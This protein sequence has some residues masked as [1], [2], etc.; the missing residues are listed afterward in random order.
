MNHAAGIPVHCI[1]AEDTNNFFTTND[2]VTDLL[3]IMSVHPMREDILKNLLY[4]KKYSE[5]VLQHLIKQ[6]I[7][8]EITYEN[9]KFYMKNLNN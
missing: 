4:E 8:K 5:D 2:I 3:S 6:E 9:N 1:A 7:I